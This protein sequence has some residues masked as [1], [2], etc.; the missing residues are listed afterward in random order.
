M[1]G[2]EFSKV[3]FSYRNRSILQ[4]VSFGVEQ[5][6]FCV[7]LGANGAGKSTLIRCANSLLRPQ[8]GHVFWNGT[9]TGKLS[10]RE[11]AKI[12]GYV[13]QSTQVRSGLNVM[14]T[15]L[16][17]R[18]PF[19]GHKAGKS[20]V[21]K[22]SEIIEAMELAEFAFRPLDQLSGGERQRVLIARALAQEPQVLL[23]DEPISNLD[24]RYQYELIQ[25]L[26][27]IS[28]EKG[29]TVVAVLHDLNLTLDYAH[30]AVLLYQGTVL[31]QGK[32]QA[33]LSAEAIEKVFQIEVDIVN[34]KNRPVIIPCK[35][36]SKDSG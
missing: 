20:D 22:A 27:Q 14:E 10:I 4:D 31:A 36:V 16:S 18:M 34:V 25:L 8:K 26:H 12:Y 1:S 21:E 5:G 32:P 23:L 35:T 28:Q 2:L 15:V 13:P 33:I 6:T 11:R 7:L 19:M 9:D 30:Q 3:A 29:I 24:L 17:G